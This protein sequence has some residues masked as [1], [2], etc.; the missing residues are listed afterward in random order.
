MNL[1]LEIKEGFLNRHVDGLPDKKAIIKIW[2]EEIENNPE[3]LVCEWNP[4]NKNDYKAGDMP[5]KGYLGTAKVIQDKHR[6]IG[7]HAWEQHN[8]AF[9]YYSIV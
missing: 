7:Y 5:D 6:G 8:Y 3:T 2:I 4:F 9:I 1:N